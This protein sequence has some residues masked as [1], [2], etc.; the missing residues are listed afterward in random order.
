MSVFDHMEIDT[1]GLRVKRKR[2]SGM[3]G[4]MNGKEECR[5]TWTGRRPFR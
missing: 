2:E 3:E 4:K 5:F 1:S